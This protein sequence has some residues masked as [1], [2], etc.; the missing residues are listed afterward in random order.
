MAKVLGAPND[1]YAGI[2]LLKKLDHNVD[3]NET[4]LILYSSDKYRLKE[5]EV[6]IKNLPV[7]TIEK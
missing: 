3:K 2:Y 6:T 1:N 5:G 4:M 7:F